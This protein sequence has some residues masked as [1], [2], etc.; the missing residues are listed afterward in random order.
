FDKLPEELLGSFGTPVFVLSMELTA[1]RKL[2]RVNTGK[3]LSALRQ[4]GYFLQM[5]PDL[6]P[7]LYF[8]D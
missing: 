4:E 1:T 3:V 2:A 6:K 8:G 7:D 5:P